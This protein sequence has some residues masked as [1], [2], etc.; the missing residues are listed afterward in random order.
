MCHQPERS[1]VSVTS[2]PQS[3]ASR[4]LCFALFHISSN[5][6]PKSDLGPGKWRAADGKMVHYLDTPF[7]DFLRM[8]LSIW[9]IKG[10]A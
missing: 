7:S 9:P 8:L 10:S 4:S 5:C 6:Y 3:M 2:S 1:M